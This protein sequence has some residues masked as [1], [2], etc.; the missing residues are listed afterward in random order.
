MQAL[1]RVQARVR[2][3]RVRMALENQTDQQNTSPEHTI[4]ARVREIE[5]ICTSLINKASYY[6]VI[7]LADSYI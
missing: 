5:V 1:V 6:L 3:R 2:A 7:Y 4:E